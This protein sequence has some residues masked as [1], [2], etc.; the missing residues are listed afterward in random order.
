MRV[1]LRC[2][3]DSRIKRGNAGALGYRVSEKYIHSYSILKLQSLEKIKISKC[4][5]DLRGFASKALVV[6]SG[7]FYLPWRR[8]WQVTPILVYLVAQC[9]RVRIHGKD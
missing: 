7:I 3:Q 1:R 5:H 2:P 4:M 8:N 6:N 9:I